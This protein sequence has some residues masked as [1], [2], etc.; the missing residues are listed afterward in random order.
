M[1]GF[2]FMKKLHIHDLMT[3]EEINN[4]TVEDLREDLNELKRRCDKLMKRAERIELLKL[5]GRSYIFG[6]DILLLPVTIGG[7]FIIAGRG[8]EIKQIINTISN[9]S[10]ADILGAAGLVSRAEIYGYGHMYGCK[11]LGKMKID[12]ESYEEIYKYALR[13][14]KEK[15]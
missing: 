5:I 4:L 14:R 8:K 9:G 12:K 7:S 2:D 3:E 13:S 1:K 15:E 6:I 11:I 10:K